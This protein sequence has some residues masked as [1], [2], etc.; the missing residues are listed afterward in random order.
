MLSPICLPAQT[1]NIYL[2]IHR[3]L[4]IYKELVTSPGYEV[5]QKKNNRLSYQARFILHCTVYS[6]N[7]VIFLLQMVQSM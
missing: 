5:H 4:R 6:T 7:Y 2:E 1:L 3:S